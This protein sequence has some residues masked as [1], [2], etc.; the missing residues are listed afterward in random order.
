MLKFT[1]AGIAAFLLA[2]GIA[3]CGGAEDP[4]PPVVDED[5]KKQSD[6]PS[7]DTGKDSPNTDPEDLDREEYEQ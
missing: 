2:F 7:N 5:G 3:G 1:K 6:R 4:A